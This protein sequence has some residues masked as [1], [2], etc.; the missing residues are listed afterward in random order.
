MGIVEKQVKTLR[1]LNLAHVTH[2]AV[3]KLLTIVAL[4]SPSLYG[5]FRWSLKIMFSV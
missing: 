3:I 2:Q 1:P 4:C 5:Q